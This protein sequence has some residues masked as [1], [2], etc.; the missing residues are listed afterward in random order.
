M[1]SKLILTIQGFMTDCPD[2]KMDRAKMKEMFSSLAPAVSSSG[3]QV[4]DIKKYS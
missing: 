3:V 4:L 1:F 2:G